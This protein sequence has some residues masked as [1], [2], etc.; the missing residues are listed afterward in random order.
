MDVYLVVARSIPSPS[1][2]ETLGVFDDQE[3]AQGF[4]D[5]A[6]LPQRECLEIHTW[7][8]NQPVR[9]PFWL[10]QGLSELDAGRGEDAETVRRD[11][12]AQLRGSISHDP[13]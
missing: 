13:D 8:L 1:Q 7:R 3:L 11:V 2:L 9:D 5:R 4:I 6:P 12:Q 10:A